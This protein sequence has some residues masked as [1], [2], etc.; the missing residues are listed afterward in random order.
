[1]RRDAKGRGS[2]RRAVNIVLAMLLF[3]LLSACATGRSEAQTDAAAP[4]ASNAPGVLINE[5][6]THT[7]PPQVDSVEFYNPTNA[8]ISMA[9]W[10][11]SD[12]PDDTDRVVLPAEAVVPPNGF[13]VLELPEDQTPRLSEMGEMVTLTAVDGNGT[14]AGYSDIAEFGAS[15]NGVSLGRV[16]VPGVE[17]PFFPL[18]KALTLGG[19]NAGPRVGPV[20]IAEI[21]YNPKDSKPEYIELLNTSDTTVLLH[22]PQPLEN[23]WMIEGVDNYYISADSMPPGASLFVAGV[24]PSL[25]RNAYGLDDSVAVV[26]PYAGSLKD[27]GERVALLAPEPPNPEDGVVPYVVVDEVSYGVKWP[28]PSEPNGNGAALLRTQLDAYGQEPTNWGASSLALESGPAAALAQSVVLPVVGGG[29]SIQWSTDYEWRL[30]GF[31]L[32]R[33]EAGSSRADA[34]PVGSGDLVLPQ[35]NRHLGSDYAV[36]DTQADAETTYTYWI[37]AEAPGITIFALATLN[38][39]PGTLVMMPLAKK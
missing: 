2:Q 32:W 5:L 6:L 38:A 16:E 13:W 18:Q 34:Q 39:L 7:D 20:V 30:K 26:G 37:E 24:S 33:G 27:S 1:M 3:L 8:P 35:G 31:A 29:R 17:K 12:G 23:R 36:I 15:P 19:P 9:G 22:G 25:F 21:M 14:P 28:W 10:W 11:F 4:D